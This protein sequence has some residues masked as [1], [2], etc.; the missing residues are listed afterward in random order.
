MRRRLVAAIAAVATLA[1]VLFAVPLGLVLQRAYRDEELLRL[2]RDTVAAT[3][4]I[5]V[6]PAS[7][8]PIE[9]P[10]SADELAVYDQR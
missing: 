1:V 3:R 5:D 9:L 10:A 7:R 4:E 2:Q 8:D 6:A